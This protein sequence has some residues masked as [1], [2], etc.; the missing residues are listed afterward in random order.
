MRY[1][2][3]EVVK[4][5]TYDRFTAPYG[6]SSAT[7]DLPM[8]SNCVWQTSV[9]TAPTWRDEIAQGKAQRRPG[10]AQPERFAKP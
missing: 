1:C 7:R 9:V 5:S 6:S 3:L 4:Q 8:A 2:D 10:Y